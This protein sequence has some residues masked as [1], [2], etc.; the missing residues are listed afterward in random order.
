MMINKFLFTLFVLSCSCS[1]L[2]GVESD[3]FDSS[4]ID[5]YQK[6]CNNKVAEGCFNVGIAYF[7][8][9]GLKKDD[10]QAK[11]YLQ[12]AHNLEP[13][14][15]SFADTLAR[16]YYYEYKTKDVNS[17]SDALNLFNEACDKNNASSCNML[18][19]IYEFGDDNTKINLSKAIAYYKKAC[20]LK[21]AESCDKLR[22]FRK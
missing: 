18:G 4:K 3:K 22:S 2:F 8:G 7:L 11:K 1:V 12:T 19:E 9:E 16:L 13:K 5:V 20:G 17:L 21:N 14:N 10:I 6:N 15:P